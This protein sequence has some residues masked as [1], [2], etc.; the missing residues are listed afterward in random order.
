MAQSPSPSMPTQIAFEMD[1]SGAGKHRPGSEM[2]ARPSRRAIGRLNTRFHESRFDAAGKQ[3]DADVQRPLDT[4]VVERVDP[5][6]TSS[7]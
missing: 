7:R 3:Q 1:T 2:T 5:F 6:V 4:G